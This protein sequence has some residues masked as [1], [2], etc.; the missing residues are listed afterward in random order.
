MCKLDPTM[1]KFLSILTFTLVTNA[2]NAQYT[3]HGQVFSDIRKEPIGFGV[4]RLS[5]QI[6]T[7]RNEKVLAKIDSLGK[8]TFSLKD[9]SN[10]FIE[11]DC[12]LDGS[13]IQRIYYSDSITRIYIKTDCYNY[14]SDRAKKDINKNDIYLLCNLG[15]PSYKLNSADSLFQKKYG[16]KYHMFG[17]QPNWSD[18]LWLYNTTVA[19]YLDKKY[20]KTW[21]KEVRWDVPFR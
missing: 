12:H 17:D 1:R 6:R 3:F 4:V 19:E 10:V 8:F 20:G 21:R 9:T 15:Y 14:N 7:P 5:S 2:T 16:I 11:I 13:K 18:C